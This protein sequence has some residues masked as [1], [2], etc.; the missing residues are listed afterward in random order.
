M[1]PRGSTTRHLDGTRRGGS[2]TG[3]PPF[4]RPACRGRRRA[5]RPTRSRVCKRG[6]THVWSRFALGNEHAPL[7][8]LGT[9]L[10]RVSSRPRPPG[11]PVLAALDARKQAWRSSLARPDRSRDPGS[12]V[13]VPEHATSRPE[14]AFSRSYAVAAFDTSG[15]L[16]RE[17]AITV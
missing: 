6:T 9:N 4:R 13:S 8:G 3:P 11:R 14:I 16:A 17:D 1:G 12:H 5:R 10:F 2:T 7:S 15:D